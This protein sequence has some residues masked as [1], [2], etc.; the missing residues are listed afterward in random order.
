MRRPPP[1]PAKPKP[2]KSGESSTHARA[3]ADRTGVREPD[4]SRIVYRPADFEHSVHLDALNRIVAG[5]GKFEELGSL[6]AYACRIGDL[7][8]NQ[9]GIGPVI[10]FETVLADGVHLIHREARG[11]IIAIKPSPHVNLVQLKARLE[12]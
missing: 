10:G 11:D 8:G 1:P 4:L 2:P 12:L 6:A 5:S 9:L 3:S 7:I